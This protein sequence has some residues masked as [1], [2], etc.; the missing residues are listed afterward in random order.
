VLFEVR[1]CKTGG[2]EACDL[3]MK[4][5]A[6]DRSEFHNLSMKKSPK[7]SSDKAPAKIVAVP[8]APQK[9]THFTRAEIRRAV[10]AVIAERGKV[11][12]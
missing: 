4:H 7:P 9:P 12:A 1:N 10:R 3:A 6:S 5:L 11:H 8:R 2:A